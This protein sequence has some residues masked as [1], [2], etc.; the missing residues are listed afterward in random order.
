MKLT[1][2]CH[3]GGVGKTT[4]AVM[5]AL[6]F[7]ETGPTV[8]IDADRQG[9]P[10]MWRRM[11]GDD[12]PAQLEVL[13]WR[14]PLSLPP[15]LAHVVV[16]TDPGEPVRL[17]A[18][19]EH[20]DTALIPVGAR[21]GDVVQLRETLRTVAEAA[22]GGTFVWGVLL[23]MVRLLT[24]ESRHSQSAIEADDVPLMRTVIP[25][26]AAIADSFG[27]CLSRSYAY[28]DLFREITEVPAHA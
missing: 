23:T 11:A 3:E 6:Q 26:S 16:D 21:L 12:W 10:S 14:D 15:E 9:P 27:E 1:V 18:A 5:L 19:L 20:C 13:P 4:S 24:R 2:G 17:R 28:A 25:Y 22:V 7:A 8:L